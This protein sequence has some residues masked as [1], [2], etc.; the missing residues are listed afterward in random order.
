MNIL[1]NIYAITKNTNI[2]VHPYNKMERRNSYY[3]KQK[4][5]NQ[6]HR[7]KFDK[8]KKPNTKQ[9]KLSDLFVGNYETGKIKSRV[10]WG[11]GMGARFD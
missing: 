11:I 4:K 7:N 8:E 1:W 6:C 9:Y 2:V 5:S 3:A 10:Y